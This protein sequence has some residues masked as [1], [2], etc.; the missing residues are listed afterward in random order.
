M[1]SDD[2]KGGFFSKDA[3]NAVLSQNGAV[4]L[5]INFGLTDSGKQELVIV[6]TDKDEIDII[7]DDAVCLDTMFACPD[8]CGNSNILNSDQWFLYLLL[9]EIM[10]DDLWKPFGANPNINW[11]DKI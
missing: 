2:R 4:G 11:C 10:R 5:R 7:S 6:G 9:K 3:I 1:S 8:R